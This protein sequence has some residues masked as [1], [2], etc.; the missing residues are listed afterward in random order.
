MIA[1]RQDARGKWSA[2]LWRLL[3]MTQLFPF[4]NWI[5]RLG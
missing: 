1:E 2:R 4:T 5:T 3:Q